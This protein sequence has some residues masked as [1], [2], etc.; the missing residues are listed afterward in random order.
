[1]VRRGGGAVKNTS[2]APYMNTCIVCVMH[3][4]EICSFTYA[5]SFYIRSIVI[6]SMSAPR[7][8]SMSLCFKWIYGSWVYFDGERT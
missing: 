5:I 6:I 2:E 4:G 1:M 3:S 8:G 7:N